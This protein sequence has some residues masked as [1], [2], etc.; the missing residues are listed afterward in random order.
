MN[1]SGNSKENFIVTGAI[2]A[3]INVLDKALPSLGRFDRKI[4]IDKPN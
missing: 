2:N 3:G 1:G 4:I